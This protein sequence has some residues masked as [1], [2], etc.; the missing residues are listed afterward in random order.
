MI[1]IILSDIDGTFL[2]DDKTTPALHAAAIKAVTAKG[3][4][5]VFVSARMPEAIYPITDELGMAHTPVIS[6]SGGLVLTADEEII[7]DKKISAED[8]K[9]ILAAMNHWQDITINY[10]TGRKWFV[11]EID[12]RVQFEMDIT[13]ATAEVKNFGE[14]LSE[15]IFP[16]KIMVICE[17][18]TCEEMERELGKKFPALNVVRSAPHLL[19]IMDKSVS[20]ATGIEVLLKHYGYT[21]DE[22]IAFGDNY[23]DIEM[24]ELIP[25]SV[26]MANAPAA[27][28]K[29]AAFVTDSNEAG[30]IYSYLIKRG[31]I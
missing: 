31:I 19:E 16:N 9:G 18:P 8:A 24:L 7:F 25:Q 10:Y 13:G 26:V 14:L 22:A 6:Y 21:L 28:K 15:N 23:N 5:F 20:K 30:G 1:K 17:P 12:R 11:E 4:K 27:V 29:L 2:K 3:L